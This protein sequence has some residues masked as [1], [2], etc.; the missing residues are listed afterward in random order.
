MAIRGHCDIL[1]PPVYGGSNP[2][3]E[4]LYNTPSSTQL[5]INTPIP[6]PEDNENEKTQQGDEG[7]MLSTGAKLGIGLGV[8]L[9]CLVGVAAVVGAATK[10]H[11]KKQS[12]IV[13]V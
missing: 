6:V 1:T 11:R 5:V 7:G 12:I 13:P 10:A 3:Y 4:G 2:V 9:G 8:G